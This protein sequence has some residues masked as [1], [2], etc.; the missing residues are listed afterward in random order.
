[1]LEHQTEKSK[2]LS[3]GFRALTLDQIN[4]IELDHATQAFFWVQFL[5]QLHRIWA[6]IRQKRNE[7]YI[8]TYL[9]KVTED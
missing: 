1:L 8:K 2:Q 9:L 4:F 3:N 7:V 6:P 5:E